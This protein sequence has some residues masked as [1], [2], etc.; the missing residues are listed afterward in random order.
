MRLEVDMISIYN[1]LVNG[2]PLVGS[3]EPRAT[4]V[5]VRRWLMAS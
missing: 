2:G 3:G 1:S 5:V 4:Y